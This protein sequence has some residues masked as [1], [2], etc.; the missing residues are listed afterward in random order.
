MDKDNLWI[1]D[2]FEI[3]R[4]A[5][6]SNRLTDKVFSFIREK[7]ASPSTF[8][9]WYDQF[10]TV[11]TVLHNREDIDVF[12][13]IDGLGVDWIPFVVQ[14]VEK[15]Q[16]D[17]VFLNEIYVATAE[18]PTCTA[19]N[20]AKL[21]ELTSGRLEK[22]GNI[23]SYAHA[24]KNYP[25]Y[26]IEE[27][28]IV[29]KCITDLLSQY[30]GKKIAIV[31]DHGISYLSQLADGMNLANINGD[32]SGRCGDWMQG[33][34]SKDN[35]Y[36]VLENGRTICALTHRSLTIKTPIGLGA[37]GGATPEEVL[38][39]I[40]VISG[41]KNASNISTELMTTEV[42]ATSAVLRYRIKGVS[43]IDVPIVKYNDTEYRLHHIGS[44]I[45][46]SERLNL[47]DTARKATIIIGDFNQMDTLSVNTGVDEDDLFGDL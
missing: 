41:K 29:E 10:K 16:L 19:N 8:M 5:K 45:Y 3:Y 4:D 17:G 20:K 6:I 43:S 1:N 18:L 2:Y 46:E 14:I 47:V 28:K 36:L 34:A 13:W 11:K 12:Y 38:V 32:H 39:P 7:N 15:H 9:M 30:N 44:G 40:I 22:L 42:I 27:L 35:K 31:S 25:G 26:L 33:N 23:D 21:E 37:H 24:H